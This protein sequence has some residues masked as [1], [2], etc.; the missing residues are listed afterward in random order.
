[1]WQLVI[2]ALGFD[3]AAGVENISNYVYFNRQALPEQYEGQIQVL[4]PSWKQHLGY[5]I[6]NLDN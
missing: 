4:F 2:P 6:I 1:L 3:L 5:G